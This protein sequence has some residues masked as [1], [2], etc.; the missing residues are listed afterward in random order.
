MNDLY[1]A[2][3]VNKKLCQGKNDYKTGGVF[4]SLLLAPKRKFCLTIN[5]FGIIQQNMTFKGFIDN[6]RLLDQSHVFDKLEGKKISAL[7]PRSWK[8]PFDNGVFIP[9]K[10]RRCHECKSEIYV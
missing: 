10:M 7:L 8:K 1:K 6:K 4:Y 5:E 3:L 9:V 2:K